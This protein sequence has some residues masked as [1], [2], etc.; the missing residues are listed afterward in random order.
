MEKEPIWAGW[1]DEELTRLAGETC[2]VTAAGQGIGRATAEAFLVEGARVIAVD[3]DGEAL[4]G[5]AVQG[6]EVHQVD[7]TDEAAVLAL[8]NK[9]HGI[10]VLFNC[11]GWVVGGTVADCDAVTLAT[12]FER[13]VM[14]MHHAIR[15]ILPGMR[16]RRY[17]SI[18]NVASVVSGIA[19]LPDRYAY[20][21]T[22][23]AVAGLT[24][25]V[26]RDFVGEGVRCNAISPGTIASPSLTGRMTASPDPKAAEQAFLARQ[27]MGRFGRP[28]EVAAL[29]VLLAS[30]EATFM[31]GANIVIDGG[32]TL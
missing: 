28:S 18:I 8:V 21:V 6:A 23:A 3:I 19:G 10:S 16:A 13:N 27:P 1:G 11:V 32:M 30:R 5:L 22:K 12:S 25:S 20:G 2:F 7:A 31:T 17:G 14:S 26:A 29:A 4:S 15:A 24:K 9:D